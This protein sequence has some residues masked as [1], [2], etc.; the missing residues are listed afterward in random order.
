MNQPPTSL[1]HLEQKPRTKQHRMR[2]RDLTPHVGERIAILNTNLMALGT[3]DVL[4]R[5][6]SGR[7]TVIQLEQ[8][9]EAILA[10]LRKLPLGSITVDGN[11]VTIDVKNPE[12]DNVVITDEVL[13]AGGHIQTVVTI[14]STLEDAYL[15]LVR[16][17]D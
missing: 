6:V 2:M 5:S 13:R 3:P 15:K 9:N 14:G 11:K 12:K 7:K 16:K 4:E 17:S 1:P 8:V 10:S